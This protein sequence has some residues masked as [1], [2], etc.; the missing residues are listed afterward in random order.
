MQI[1]LGHRLGRTVIPL[2]RVQDI[3]TFFMASPQYLN[4]IDIERNPFLLR[5]RNREK[6]FQPRSRHIVM[7]QLPPVESA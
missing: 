6:R 5:E 4:N 3:G 7:R 2:S 1:V